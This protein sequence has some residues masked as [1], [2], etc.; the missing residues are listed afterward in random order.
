MCLRIKIFLDIYL[1]KKMEN[2]VFI[3]LRFVFL[4]FNGLWNINV[5]DM[6]IYGFFEYDCGIL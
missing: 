1:C 3:L 2:I 6:L 5:Y 4:K